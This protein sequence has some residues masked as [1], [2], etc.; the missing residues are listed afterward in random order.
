MLFH[1]YQSMSCGYFSFTLLNL[2]ILTM[3]RK[4]YI[5]RLKTKIV[6][7]NIIHAKTLFQ[8]NVFSSEEQ[9]SVQN[10]SDSNQPRINENELF[11]LFTADVSGKNLVYFR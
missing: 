6:W 3:L 7:K 10:L 4:N 1:E 11:S 8:T 9:P 5:Q 2:K